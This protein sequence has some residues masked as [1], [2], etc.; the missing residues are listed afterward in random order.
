VLNQEA[1]YGEDSAVSNNLARLLF[2]RRRTE[3]LACGE[4]QCVILF[5]EIILITGYFLL[6]RICKVKV[7]SK[8]TPYTHV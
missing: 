1:R 5:N 4:Y 7:F 3:K 6:I 2:Q 8:E